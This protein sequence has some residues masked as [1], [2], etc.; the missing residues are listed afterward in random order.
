M[1]NQV[2][3]NQ[4]IRFTKKLLTKISLVVAQ[5]QNYGAPRQYN[6]FEKQS[7]DSNKKCWR[8]FVFF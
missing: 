2:N 5:G 3:L 4:L 1:S 8:W 7:I 6:S